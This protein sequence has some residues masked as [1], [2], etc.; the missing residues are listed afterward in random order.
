[1][2]DN[3]NFASIIDPER[4]IYNFDIEILDDLGRITD[5]KT[6]DLIVELVNRLKPAHSN[7]LVKFPR[8]HC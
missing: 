3:D 8:N 1:M 5:E 4:G 7:A 2:T 6:E